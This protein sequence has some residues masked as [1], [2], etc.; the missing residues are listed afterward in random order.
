MDASKAQTPE[1][2][3]SALT[4]FFHSHDRALKAAT[5]LFHGKKQHDS[6]AMFDDFKVFSRKCINAE[7]ETKSAAKEL[8]AKLEEGA[9]KKNVFGAPSTSLVQRHLDFASPSAAEGGSTQTPANSTVR[10]VPG[11]ESDSS[12]HELAVDERLSV[13]WGGDKCWYEGTVL[14]VHSVGGVKYDILYDDGDK[15]DA[16]DLSKERRAAA[17]LNR[18]PICLLARPIPRRQLAG[19]NGSRQRPTR[20]GQSQKTRCRSSIGA[21]P[22]ARWRRTWTT[23][24]KHCRFGVW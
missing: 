2:W 20:L 10:D 4:R 23:S 11:D 6:S 18:R 3:S 13:Y 9:K 8:I 5:K 14:A 17:P 16:W 12:E 1:E 22:R 21:A 19:G 15:W 24:G 7:E